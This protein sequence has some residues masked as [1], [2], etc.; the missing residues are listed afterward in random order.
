MR[1][2][3]LTLVGPVSTGKTAVFTRFCR[4]EFLDEIK[5]TIGAMYHAKSI[6]VGGV[7]CDIELW[8][9]AGQE[10]FKSLA[11]QYVRDTEGIIFVVDVTEEKSLEECVSWITYAREGTSCGNMFLFGNKTD[12]TEERKV[13]PEQLVEFAHEFG[14]RVMEGSAK[15][16]LNIADLFEE[17]AVVVLAN[18]VSHDG[19][20]VTLVSDGKRKK[21]CC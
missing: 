18:D 6:K 17:I 5:P 7:S 20:I 16:G 3:K 2:H 19:E 14:F 4:D 21:E 10:K 1:L 8:D 11:T 15:T 12:L 13:T 9:T